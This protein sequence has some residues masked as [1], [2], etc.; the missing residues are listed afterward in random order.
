[1][2]QISDTTLYK[3]RKLIKVKHKQSGFS[4]TTVKGEQ[5]QNLAMDM[6]T[7]NLSESP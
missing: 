1:M 7:N 5:G 4:L 3:V 6:V 2:T